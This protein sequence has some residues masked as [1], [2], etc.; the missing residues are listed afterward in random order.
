M[1]TGA[2][3]CLFLII[4]AGLACGVERPLEAK[5]SDPTE[6]KFEDLVKMEVPIV[7]AAS[8]YNQKVTEAPA[9]VTVISSDEVKKYGHRTLAEVLATVPGLFVNSDRNYSFLGIR[10]FSLGDYN[11]RVLLLVNGHRL[12][13]SLSDSAFIGTEFILDVDLID[14]VEIIRGPGS[15]LYGNNAFFG[16]INVI[17]RKGRDLP[18]NGFEVSGEAGSFDSY[19]GR[20]TYGKLFENGLELLF[21]GSIYDS[22]GHDRLF[23]RQFDN[24][25]Q[26]NGVAQNAD[27]DSF[28]NAFASVSF[29]DFTFEG[30]FITREKQNPTAQFLTDF[31]DPRFRTVDDRGYANFKYAHEF[32]EIVDVTAQVYYDFHNFD[33][34]EP[35]VGVLYKDSQKADWWGAEVQLTKK[36]Q[37]LH[38]FTFGGEFRDDFRQQERFL[39]ITNGMVSKALDRSRQNH[40]IYFQGDVAIVTNLHL[41]A[42]VRYDQY[43]DFDPAF[44]PRVAF[45]YN[46]LD[47][48]VLK[49]IYGT[50]FRA[51]N[52]FELSDQRNQAIQPETISTY[53]L[54][55]EQGIGAHVRSSLA[56]FYNQIDDLITF[57]S[58]PG[59]QRFENLSGAEAEGM[60]LAFDGFWPGVVRGRASYTFQ[61]TE[62]STTGRTLTDSPAHLGKLNISVPL[63]REKIF[64]G[65][66]FLYVSRRTTTH[67]T[68]IGT[69][70][71]GSDAAGFGLINFTLFSQNL[72]KNLDLSA[73]VYNLLDKR[74]G[75]PATPFHQQDIIEQDG[76]SFRVKLTYRF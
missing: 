42:G 36:I 3:L 4:P 41:N 29:Q 73:S 59:H 14:R 54:V 32:P 19:K 33:I 43:G 48:T 20:V 64:A 10:G 16:V 38:T 55:Y 62:D 25:A 75:N 9:S 22:E 76:R 53:E 5:S 39:N 51:P 34:T 1:T 74:Y 66:E 23:Y 30:G 15:S 69:A 49:A 13:N 45:I 65:I 57:N 2:L 67:L 47:E 8:K 6:I 12:N 72:V 71:A 7:G 68:P 50:A 27:S 46:P 40:G 60:E 56:G 52:F 70:E 17:T 31:N 11:N 37:D 28:K 63:W 44:N 35:Y 18:G 61:H 26:N 24:P 21:S 58:A